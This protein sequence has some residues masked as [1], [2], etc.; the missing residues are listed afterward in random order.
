MWYRN[1][2]FQPARSHT[3][4]TAQAGSLCYKSKKMNVPELETSRLK[5]IRLTE[6]HYNDLFDIFSDEESMKYWDDPPMESID[7][8]KNLVEFLDKRIEDGRGIC[9]G[10]TLKTAP[11][12]VIGMFT[13]NDFR[14]DGNAFIGYILARKHWGQG[15]STEAVGVAVEYGFSQMGVH[16]I[17]A[18]VEP[19][20]I[21]SEKL[22]LKIGFQKEGILRE[23]T[24]NKGKYQD[25]VY[26]G[27]LKTDKRNT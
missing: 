24:F 25:M 5:L 12:K 26:F 8:V 22:L 1:T 9:W 18:H 3:Q 4:T 2:G 16:R 21:A 14:K 13:Y 20:N 27:L 19:K 10:I 23:R 7:E 6:S 15:L 17:E 11:K